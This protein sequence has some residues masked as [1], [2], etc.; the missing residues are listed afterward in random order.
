[1][2]FQAQEAFTIDKV[3]FLT[4]TVTTGAIMD[5]RVETV[6]TTDGFP[7]GTLWA[8]NTNVSH[9]IEDTDD[10]VWLTTASLTAAAT[11]AKGDQVAVVIVN[12]AVSP[13]NMAL[14]GWTIFNTFQTELF[15]FT[16]SWAQTAQSPAMIL[17][18]SS[19]T[20]MYIPGS[21]PFDTASASNTVN[22][23][24]TPDEYGLKFQLPFPAR[25]N[26][27]MFWKLAFNAGADFD[28]VLYDAADTA[29]FTAAQSVDQ[30]LFQARD[31]SIDAIG[32]SETVDLSANTV[33][34]LV[35]KPTTAN[36]MFIRYATFDDA[37]DLRGSYW[38]EKF[39]STE[40]TTNGGS[41]SAWTDGTVEQPYMSLHLSGFDDGL[42][43]GLGYPNINLRR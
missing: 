34:R 14:M 13:G 12:P 43:V 15:L 7:S 19:S 4:R 40:R 22:T 10:S 9:T 26:G 2:V 31:V 5:V 23:G 1:M 8:T 6:S 24:S 41:P 42:N 28:I 30:S 36:S 11:I 38:G 18:N 29:L 21:A 27:C 32:F 33:Y 25:I 3:K 37:A 16:S 39:V 17:L 20:V 35:A